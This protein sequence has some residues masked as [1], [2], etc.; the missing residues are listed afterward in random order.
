MSILRLLVNTRPSKYRD[1]VIAIF[2][3]AHSRSSLF[4]FLFLKCLDF[5]DFRVYSTIL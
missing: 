1:I 5:V 4:V 2:L 3:L